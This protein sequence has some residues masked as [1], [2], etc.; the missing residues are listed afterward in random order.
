LGDALILIGTGLAVGTVALVGTGY[1]GYRL[2]ENR[3]FYMGVAITQTTVPLLLGV[4][5]ILDVW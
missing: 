3:T 4:L 5:H 2:R 1:L